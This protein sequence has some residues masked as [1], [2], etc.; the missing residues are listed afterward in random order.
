[1]ETHAHHLHKAPGK[2]FWHY[3]SEF[4][5]LGLAVFSGFLAENFREHKIEHY[6]EERY[7]KNLYE[8]LKSDTAIYSE[9]NKSTLELMDIVDSRMHNNR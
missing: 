8:D 3:F 2:K 1:M 5:M 4:I 7:I 6:R 9:Y